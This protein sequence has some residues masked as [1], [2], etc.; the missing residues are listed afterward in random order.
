MKKIISQILIFVIIFNF[1]FSGFLQ[2][3]VEA[4]EYTQETLDKA[5]NE[6]TTDSPGGTLGIDYSNTQSTSSAQVGNL[7][8]F[9][10][11]IPIILIQI[12]NLTAR[13]A[14][15]I[16]YE[17]NM[18]KW[19]T[20]QNIVFGNYYLLNANMFQDSEQLAVANKDGNEM[21][22]T[23][24][25]ATMDSLKEI[26]SQWYY[27]LKLISLVL[28]LLTLIYIGIRMAISTIATDQAKYKKMLI[29]W[30]Q[31]IGIILILPYIMRGLVYLNEVLLD[32]LISI[33]KG[34]ID[35]GQQSFE[36]NLIE[37][38]YIKYYT[39]G[40]MELAGYTIAYIILLWAQFKFF[41]MYIKRVFA[42]AFLTIISPLITI[43]YSMDKA[44]D[45]KAQAFSAWLQEYAI[46]MLV[47]PLQAMIYLI[48][49]FSANEIA[50]TAPLVGII[51]LLSL[52]RA[53]RI[54]KTIF[55]MRNLSSMSTMRLF[56]KGK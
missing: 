43:T 39:T 51:F 45:G 29:G 5:E 35:S 33:R 3:K 8:M 6:G 2:Y 10:S 36:K 16:D 25:A 38:I 13:D 23:R 14:G 28:G 21:H 50:T 53:E 42:V 44:G 12:V 46:N 7:S 31:S 56:K 37:T 20:I 54:I 32:L 17:N 22:G 52:T 55:N 30:V 11:V 34:L 48:F 1:I 24:L 15:F 40:G 9:L 41:M 27:I 49:M 26:V 47:Q 4:I 19:L 18:E